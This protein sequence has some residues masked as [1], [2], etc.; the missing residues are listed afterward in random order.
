MD[1]LLVLYLLSLLVTMR[2]DDPHPSNV[3]AELESLDRQS[4]DMEGGG[5]K[6]LRHRLHFLRLVYS[7]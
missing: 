1:C 7:F 3:I 5:L 4:C 6:E 2:C